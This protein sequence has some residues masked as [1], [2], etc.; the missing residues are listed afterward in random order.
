MEVQQELKRRAGLSRPYESIPYPPGVNLPLD[1]I[2]AIVPKI[3]P[4]I[5]TT[6]AAP[7]L[8]YPKKGAT[9]PKRQNAIKNANIFPP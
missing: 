1:E 4:I 5:K 8:I 7:K 2:T 6:A 3:N 9:N